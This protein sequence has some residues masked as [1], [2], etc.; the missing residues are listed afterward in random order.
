[1]K[2]TD[3]NFDAINDDHQVFR[4][5]IVHIVNN[6]LKRSGL[7][8]C[9][10]MPRLHDGQ[11]QAVIICYMPPINIPHGIDWKKR[12]KELPDHLAFAFHVAE[13]TMI[14]NTTYGYGI[15]ETTFDNKP[16]LTMHFRSI[17]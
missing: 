15:Q 16:V 8:H 6:D 7:K 4:D 13:R 3:P 11:G 14:P 10:E 1:M 2:Y 17:Q 9:P 12:V 5:L